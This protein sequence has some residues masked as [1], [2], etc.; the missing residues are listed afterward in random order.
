MTLIELVI[1]WFLCFVI[2]FVGHLISPRWG[3]LVGVIPAIAVMIVMLFFQI[4]SIF[5]ELWKAVSR[6][7]GK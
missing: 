3:W 4:R 2:G 6:R 7:A 1:F 5:V